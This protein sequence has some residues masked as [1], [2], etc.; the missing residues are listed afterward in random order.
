NIQTCSVGKKEPEVESTPAGSLTPVPTRQTTQQPLTQEQ[1]HTDQPSAPTTTVNSIPVQTTLQAP[2]PVC[3]TKWFSR[4]SPSATGDYELLYYI[5]KEY[6][7]A[8]CHRP[9][10]IEVQTIHGVPALQTGQKFAW[11][12]PV[13]GF[14]CINAEQG[15]RAFCYDYKVRFTCPD[16][17]CSGVDEK[18]G[19]VKK[20]SP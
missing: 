14:A 15:K 11:N 3:K 16:S 8:V 17:F 5:R 12:D 19:V 13:N 7:G 9:S 1:D 18:D 2:K 10:A 6:P 20:G 4:D